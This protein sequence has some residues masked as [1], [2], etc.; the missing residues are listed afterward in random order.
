ML[1]KRLTKKIGIYMV[2]MFASKILPFLLIPIYAFYVSSQTLGQ[3]DLIKT[4]MGIAKPFLYIAIWEAILRFLLSE[5]DRKKKSA[6]IS[7]SAIFILIISI[8]IF[9]LSLICQLS[10]NFYEINFV[11]IGMMYITHS[12]A[13]IWQYYARALE[14]NRL[15]VNAGIIGTVVNIIFV[16]LFIV[17]LR[18]E[19]NGLIISYILGQLSIFIYIEIKIKIIPNISIEKFE[20]NILKAMLV[21]S[22]PLVLNL[23]SSWL[24]SG[25]GRLLIVNNIGAEANGLYS[26]ATRFSLIISTLGS[27]VT[28]AMIEEAIISAKTSGFN[29]KF[30]KIIEDIFK[31]FQSI[32]ILAL[33]FI[34]VFYITIQ[35]TEFYS[36]IE[37][38]P[39]LLFYSVSNT[40]SYVIGSVFQAISKTKYQFITTVIGATF[41]VIISSIL[42]SYLGIYA[43]IIGQVTG[44]IIMLLTRYFFVNRYVDLKINWKT[45]NILNIIFIMVSIISLFMNYI[46][47][48]ILIPIVLFIVYY[49]NREL[50]YKLF[51]SIIKK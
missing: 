50:L 29:S 20:I 7:T 4:I 18:M 44:S 33:P 16:I 13:F 11:L 2:G 43:V 6:A 48:F 12:V 35:N 47:I 38:V 14:Y 8:T 34:A 23:A 31:I 49:F 3:Y 1:E 37:F 10:I 25:Y 40:L 27:V 26:F 51:Q 15:Y 46:L 28:M 42:I 5:N 30:K 39:W 32:T 36:S 21:F 41:T 24:L 17:V 22:F 45:I 9:T 19:L